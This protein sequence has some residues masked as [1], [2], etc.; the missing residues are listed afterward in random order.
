MGRIKEEDKERVVGMTK[1]LVLPRNILT[2]LK[3]KN[4][5]SLTNIKQVYNTRTRWLKGIRGDKTDAILDFE[6]GGA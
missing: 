2:D 4:K 1:S 6:V 3:Q 5:E